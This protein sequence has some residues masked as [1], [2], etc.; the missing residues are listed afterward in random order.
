MSGADDQPQ[1][2]YTDGLRFT[3]TQCGNCCTGPSGYVWFDPEELT[4]MARYCNLTET[5]FLRTHARKLGKRWSL[6]ER[7]TSHGFDC[8]FLRRDPD[9]KA[10]CGIYPVRPKQCRTW[11]FWPEN[12][13]SPETWEQA[14]AGCPGMA[15]GLE[16][17][18]KHYTLHQ[19]RIRRD[20]PG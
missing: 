18:G 3:C 15:T 16:G 10:L 6:A 1:E 19:I 7:K 4:A 14:A 2:W 12:L 13:Q 9:G 5:Q 20:D 17:R 8:V 11:P